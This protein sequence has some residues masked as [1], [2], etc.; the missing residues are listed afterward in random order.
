LEYDGTQWQALN[1]R[2]ITGTLLAS[3]NLSDVSN[4]AT[5]LTNL[6]IAQP[7]QSSF[8]NLAAAWASNTTFTISADEI[9]LEN[10]SGN[11]VKAS[12]VS[13]TVNSASSGA[14]GLDTG[15]IAASTWYYGYII[16]PTGGGTPAGLMSLSATAPTLP[17]GYT[18]KSG[19]VSAVRTDGSSHFLGFAQK[20]RDIDYVVGSNLSILPAIAS[21]TAGSVTTPTWSAASY[22][23]AAPISACSKVKFLLCKGRS[24]S[25]AGGAI[26]APNASYGNASTN[27]PPLAVGN[28]TSSTPGIYSAMGEFIVVGGVTTVQY[29]SG[30]TDTSLSVMGFTLNI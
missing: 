1:A 7:V 24:T 12:S 13:V 6:G 14:N 22:A 4:A 26:A 9:T 28:A 8:K 18:L 17:G 20:G 19:A 10:G 15:S 3:N 21:G 16:E 30:D 29:A 2:S 23:T 25:S 27:P 5:A 11:T